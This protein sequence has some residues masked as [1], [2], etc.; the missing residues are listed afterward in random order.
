MAA[1]KVVSDTPTDAVELDAL[2]DA[3]AVVEC[4]VVIQGQ[5]LG[6]QHLQL[7]RHGQTILGPA[8]ANAEEHLAGDEQFPSGAALLAI[9]IGQPLGIGLIGPA[10][11]QALHPI[12]EHR[13]GNARGGLDARAH[14]IA[15]PGL[16]RIGGIAVVA[17]QIPGT[18][19]HVGASR[20][21]QRVDVGAAGSE[22]FEAACGQAA[23]E[24]PHHGTHLAA[25]VLEHP[26][27]SPFPA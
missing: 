20:L 13:I 19:G 26:H 2:T 17:D 11:P 8:R 3:V 4:M 12:L 14:C 18:G 6:R 9:E 24:A 5:H 22:G 25:Q 23:L 15:G 1:Q 27:H 16:D 21:D 10:Q 7:Q